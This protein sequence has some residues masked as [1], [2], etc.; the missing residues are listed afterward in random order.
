MVPV[1]NTVSRAAGGRKLDLPLGQDVAPRPRSV[2]LQVDHN[3]GC[4]GTDCPL[5]R[6]AR[7]PRGDE[8]TRTGGAPGGC[9]RQDAERAEKVR[10]GPSYS[11]PVAYQ[12]GSARPASAPG[13]RQVRRR[14]GGGERHCHK[15]RRTQPHHLALSGW[16]YPVGTVRLALPV[17]T[18]RAKGFVAP[19]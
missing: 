15:R 13:K 9:S 5:V 7:A 11:G 17:G 1:S 8:A 4:P 18:V 10:T 19:L 16:H 14:K 2:Y 6:F 3:T 12:A